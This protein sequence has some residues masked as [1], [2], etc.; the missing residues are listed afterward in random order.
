VVH[1]HRLAPSREPCI[2]LFLPL[3]GAHPVGYAF[4]EVSQA[5]D[6][7]HASKPHALSYFVAH[8]GEGEGDA[9]T[10]TTGGQARFGGL[11]REA[12]VTSASATV[13][14]T[15]G[16]I[17][18]SITATVLVKASVSKTLAAISPAITCQN[19]IRA[20]LAEQLLPIT[21]SGMRSEPV[22]R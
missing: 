17:T 8:A 9:L 21:L 5:D 15:S 10:D 2:D 1:N 19:T 11:A 13:S 4:V 3:P 14:A 6:S 18:A 7:L 20:Q 16:A 12:L 22:L